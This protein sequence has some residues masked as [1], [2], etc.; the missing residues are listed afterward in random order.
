MEICLQLQ[1]RNGF[2]EEKKNLF[3]LLTK[4]HIVEYYG[5]MYQN[6]N[7]INDGWGQER[8]TIL[9]RTIKET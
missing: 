6:R 1:L 2:E 9:Q 3:R 7:H 4:Q 8:G 5:E